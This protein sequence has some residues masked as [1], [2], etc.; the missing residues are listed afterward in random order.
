MIYKKYS[1]VTVPFPFT[2]KF[3]NKKRP[4]LIVS[5]EKYQSVTNHCILCMITSAKHTSWNNDIP[6][7]NTRDTGLSTPSK[8]RFKVFSLPI[9][10]I[11]ETIGVLNEIEILTVKNNLQKIL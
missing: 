9:D 7:I 10:L 6:I 8:I 1:I 11:I 3:L 5:D 2:E 4:A